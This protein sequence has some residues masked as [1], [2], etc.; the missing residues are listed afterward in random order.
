MNHLAAKPRKASKPAGLVRSCI[1]F[2][3]GDLDIMHTCA[4]ASNLDALIPELQTP[5]KSKDEGADV[6]ARGITTTRHASA[7]C[8]LL[9][10]RNQNSDTYRRN[11]R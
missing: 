7:D 6:L 11:A 9:R 4:H 5:D 8:T 3:A 1:C 2:V 10:A